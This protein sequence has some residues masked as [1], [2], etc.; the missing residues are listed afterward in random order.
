MLFHLSFA[1]LVSFLILGLDV[2]NSDR[3][4]GRGLFEALLDGRSGG[5]SGAFK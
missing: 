5:V 2:I 1:E 4:A 3:L